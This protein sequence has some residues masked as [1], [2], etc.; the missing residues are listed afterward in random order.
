MF[1][2]QKIQICKVCGEENKKTT[3]KCENCG[4][5]AININL[6]C[7]TPTVILM[8]IIDALIIIVI[9]KACTSF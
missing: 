9:V 8:G 2:N 5:V 4:T 6:G 1:K 7:S 3:L